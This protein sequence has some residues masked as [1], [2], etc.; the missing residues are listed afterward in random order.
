M[1][2]DRFKLSSSK[3]TEN[4]EKTLQEISQDC[5]KYKLLNIFAARKN[6]KKYNLLMYSSIVLGP[7]TGILSI[8]SSQNEAIFSTLITVYS[9]F[10]GVLSAVIK[11]SG[12]GEKALTHK[13]IASKYASLE[14]NIKRQLSLAREE[15]TEAGEYL[16]WITL[17]YDELYSSSPL[18]SDDIQVSYK[19]E[20]DTKKESVPTQQPVSPLP[21]DFVAVDLSKYSDGK[22]K[23]EMSR[24]FSAK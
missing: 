18:I 12:F 22:M 5:R 1:E 20:Q 21:S 24:L 10:S 16:E 19:E 23:Y 8:V 11:Y 14:S 13:T 6:E 17:S 4:I 2:T 3:W 15:R 7:I 9:F